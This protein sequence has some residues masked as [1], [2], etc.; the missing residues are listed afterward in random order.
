MRYS[1]FISVALILFSCNFK[2]T[3]DSVLR[4]FSKVEHL[5]IQNSIIKSS[6]IGEIVDMLVTKVSHQR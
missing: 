5:K 3:N 6:D 2:E 1:L 4:E